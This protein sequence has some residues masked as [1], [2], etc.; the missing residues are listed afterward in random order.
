MTVAIND[1]QKISGFYAFQYK[2]DPHWL[3]QVFNVSPEAARDHDLAH[4]DVDDE[5]DLHQDQ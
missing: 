4:A 3:I 2:V 5:V 1:K